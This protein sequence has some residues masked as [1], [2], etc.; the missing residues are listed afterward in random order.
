MFVS[1]H[2]Y[3]LT[4]LWIQIFWCRQRKDLQA[5][6]GGGGEGR[7]VREGPERSFTFCQ[8]GCQ[9]IVRLI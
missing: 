4:K 2:T 8:E 9:H 7:G 3:L 5:G 6:K 1:R